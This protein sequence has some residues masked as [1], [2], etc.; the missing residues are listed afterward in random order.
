MMVCKVSSSFGALVHQFGKVL[1]LQARE[2]VARIHGCA[3]SR[4]GH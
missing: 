1:G 2:L 4:G 3:K